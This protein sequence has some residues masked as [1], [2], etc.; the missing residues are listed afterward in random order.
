M[1]RAASTRAAASEIPA[2]RVSALMRPSS[3]VRK[4]HGR[5]N[6]ERSTPRNAASSTPTIPPL[7]QSIST[8]LVLEAMMRFDIAHGRGF[9]PHD[10]GVG[11]GAAGETPYAFEHGAGGDAGGGEHDVAAREI[12]ERVLPIEIG[13]AHLVSAALLVVVAKQEPPL[14]LA[15]DAAQR[16]RRQHALGRAA[17]AHVDVHS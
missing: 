1:L 6:T 10:Q 12:Q 14:H 3:T 2:S 4:R 13:D 11:D 8:A 7:G 17:G 15:S 9:G 16:R 5:P